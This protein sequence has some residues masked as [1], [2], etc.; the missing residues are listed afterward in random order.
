MSEEDL[1]PG[2]RLREELD[3]L[4]ER[5]AAL[6]G[7]VAD[8]ERDRDTL[9]AQAETQA[10]LMRRAEVRIR[11]ARL[12]LRKMAEAAAPSP[13]GESPAADPS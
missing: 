11:R 8:L 1:D 10:D 2:E 7:R 13:Q 12:A 9:Y 4:H 6:S 3:E 5:L